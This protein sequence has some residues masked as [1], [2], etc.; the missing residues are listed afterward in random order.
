M[1]LGATASNR[2]TSKRSEVH[3]RSAAKRNLWRLTPTAPAITRGFRPGKHELDPT[4]GDYTLAKDGIFVCLIS[5][6]QKRSK[7]LRRR[8]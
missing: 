3:Q 2:S 1:S 5:K 7:A 6:I 8:C 4:V